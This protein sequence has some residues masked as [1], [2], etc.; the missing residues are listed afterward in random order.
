MKYGSK[1]NKRFEV[2]LTEEENE[3][4]IL[5]VKK[6]KLTRRKFLLNLV[7]LYD[8]I[9]WDNKRKDTNRL[10]RKAIQTD[11]KAK[12]RTGKR[13]VY[14]LLSGVCDKTGANKIHSQK[15]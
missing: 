13:R 11:T 6:S 15:R 7:K 4:L 3:I 2:R 9:D 5:A 8:K 14:Y 10:L 1:T 12:A